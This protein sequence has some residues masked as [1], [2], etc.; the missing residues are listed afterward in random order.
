[1]KRTPLRLS[2]LERRRWIGRRREK[3]R[4]S[5][6]ERDLVHLDLV[7]RL[8][9]YAASTIPGHVCEGG[10]EAD[11]AGARPLGRKA[12]DDTAIPLCSLAHRQRTDF[13]GPFRS[14]TKDRM[15]EWLA[16]GIELA[17]EGVA[18]LKAAG[19]AM[20]GDV[21]STKLN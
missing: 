9:C 10:I 2:P 17:R 5:E 12:H 6:R 15:R 19:A 20:R 13:S 1:M 11:H 8:P 3:P 4:R 14:W 7:H 16:R 18:A 21:A